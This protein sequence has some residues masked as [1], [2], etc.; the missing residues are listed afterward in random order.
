MMH[1][2]SPFWAQKSKNFRGRQPPPRCLR[3]FLPGPRVSSFIRGNLVPLG[4]EIPL[5]RGHQRGVPS[6]E[7]VICVLT[8]LVVLLLEWSL[9]WWGV[10][11]RDAGGAWPARRLLEPSSVRIG[12][13]TTWHRHQFCSGVIDLVFVN[14]VDNYQS[15]SLLLFKCCFRLP[16]MC[17]WSKSD[18][19]GLPLGPLNPLKSLF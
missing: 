5:E 19:A 16:M 2:N 15:L 3:C 17:M 14:S 13:S 8:V 4:E 7:I 1:Q 11:P 9:W 18:V 10:R 12:I 6:L